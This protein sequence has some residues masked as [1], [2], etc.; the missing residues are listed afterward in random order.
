M[1]QNALEI[2]EGDET[3]ESMSVAFKDM[4]VPNGGLKSYKVIGSE[5]YDSNNSC[6]V[7]VEF[8]FNN[9]NTFE[10]SRVL[11]KIEGRWYHRL[12]N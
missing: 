7:D 3:F 8:S 10:T 1:P 4:K 2:K 5:F 9:G 11:K 6:R 12:G